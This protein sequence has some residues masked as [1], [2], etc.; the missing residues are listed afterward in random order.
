M[1]TEKGKTSDEIKPQEQVEK[2]E[3]KLQERAEAE[4]KTV[5]DIKAEDVELA[6]IIKKYDSDPKKIAK[7]YKSSQQEFSKLSGEATLT[8]DELAQL[9]NKPAQLEQMSPEQIEEKFQARITEV[10]YAKAHTELTYALANRMVEDRMGKFEK[11]IADQQVDMNI[12]S[13]A[14]SYPDINTYAP[15]IKKRLG[16]MS[17]EIKLQADAVKN[18][19]FQIIGEK[20]AKGELKKEIEKETKAKLEKNKKILGQTIV[21]EPKSGTTSDGSLSKEQEEERLQ[22]GLSVE[23]YLEVLKY[24]QQR[25]KDANRTPRRSIFGK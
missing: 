10:G 2:E 3:T 13:L 4:G 7:A 20:T 23:K 15:E 25:D 21:G 6:G 9:K 5:E 1:T 11:V 22:K 14:P 16:N 12:R 18:V 19:Y 17:L 8:K 24:H